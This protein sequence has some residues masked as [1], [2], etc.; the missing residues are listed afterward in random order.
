MNQDLHSRTPE[1]QK[2]AEESDHFSRLANLFARRRDGEYQARLSPE[3]NA[4][5]DNF[6]RR[7]GFSQGDKIPSNWWIENRSMM[8]RITSEAENPSVFV[9]DL[10]VRVQRTNG[11]VESGWEIAARVE[12]NGILT[13]NNVKRGLTKKIPLYEVMALN[14]DL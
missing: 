2:G 12:E 13:V 6:L 3:E 1:G 4:Q 9:P 11:E 8:R 14:P 7:C 10:E 5:L